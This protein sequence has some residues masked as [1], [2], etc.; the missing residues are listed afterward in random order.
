[1][2]KLKEHCD[3]FSRMKSLSSAFTLTAITISSALAQDNGGQT[4]QMA[5]SPA[6]AIAPAPGSTLGDSVDKVT[7]AWFGGKI[8]WGKVG[9]IDAKGI[10]SFWLDGALPP[11]TPGAGGSRYEF[12]KEDL[13]GDT[14][15][16]WTGS[17]K[18]GSIPVK[19]GDKL[20][21]YVFLD[22][23]DPPMEV[24]LQ[25]HAHD[26]YANRAFWGGINKVTH[27]DPVRVG[28]LP[29]TGKW[30]R[31]EVDPSRVGR[32]GVVFP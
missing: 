9:T 15:R 22:P 21:V 1:M 18:P 25:L 17:G 10:E 12:G 8:K 7:L 16:Q 28:L 11:E 13:S 29:E 19:P 23:V 27:M 30:V 14:F 2:W 24:L 31:L 32:S 4:P 20:F 5:E 6:P 3:N 26:S